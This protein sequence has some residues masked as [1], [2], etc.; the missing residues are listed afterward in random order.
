MAINDTYGLC[1]RFNR[2]IDLRQALWANKFFEDMKSLP[3]LIK[4]EHEALK[5]IMLI[6]FKLIDKSSMYV[7]EYA[8]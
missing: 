5:V 8:Q 6:K 4:Q 3:G 7:D 2:N 1:H